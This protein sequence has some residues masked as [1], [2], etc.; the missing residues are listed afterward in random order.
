[1][2]KTLIQLEW[3]EWEGYI[4]K[5]KS[6]F[7]IIRAPETPNTSGVFQKIRSHPLKHRPPRKKLIM[8]KNQYHQAHDQLKSNYEIAWKN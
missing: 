3:G 5:I 8:M 7:N 6:T 2:I 1:M 4:N